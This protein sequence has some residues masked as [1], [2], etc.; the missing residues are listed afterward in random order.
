M[1]S[2]RLFILAFLLVILGA[3]LLA[4]PLALRAIPPRYAARFLPQPLLAL[5]V[6]EQ[7]SPILPTVARPA[8]ASFLLQVDSTATAAAL[9]PPTF[10]PP[11]TAVPD[12]PAAEATSAPVIPP[13][14]TPA[15][16]ATPL[17]IP[18]AARISGVRHEFQEWN[19]C[20]PATLAMT[21]SVFDLN[22]TQK[23]TAPILKPNPEDRNVSP[24]EMAAFVN[25]RTDF[26][27]LFRANGRAATVKRLVANGIPVILEIGIEPPGEFRWMGWYGH[28]M[29]VVAYD[30]AQEQFWIYDSW[31]GTSEVPLE[32]AGPDGR[33]LTYEALERDW[34][35]FNR[36]YI[37][38]YRPEQAQL[39]ADI[40]GEDMDDA[41]MWANALET[42]RQDAA[43]DPENAFY[44]FNLGTAYNA[45]GD[46]PSAAAAFDQA[47]A[48]GLP[49]RMLWYQFGPYEAYYQV[50]RYED[51]ILLA[52]TTLKDRP[53]FEESFYY[54]GLAQAALGDV[55]GARKSLSKAADL[56]PNFPLAAEALAHLDTA[57]EN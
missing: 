11:P 52:D 25:E 56:N 55:A 34:P 33:I 14:E 5:T 38:V 31:L 16:T 9:L 41:V 36:N 51:V 8:D 32:N 6:P 17:P 28:Y 29:L 20:G 47:R 3:A 43:A 4:L 45:Q 30:D 23:D 7:K 27:A 42:S 13:T 39:V 37:A 57:V 15:P 50:G 1:V 46:Y 48:I 12:Q 21:L 26:Q 2:K 10:T 44:W 35:H 19:N 24:H 49:W 53:Y 18:P 22:L 40:I 54:K